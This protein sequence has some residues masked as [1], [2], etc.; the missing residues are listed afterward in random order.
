MMQYEHQLQPTH[1]DI[2]L[3]QTG[4][5]DVKPL[6]A[7]INDPANNAHIGRFETWAHDFTELVAEQ[8]V[9]ESCDDIRF[10]TKMQYRIIERETSDMIGNVSL[11]NRAGRS[12]MLGYFLAQE[13]CGKGYM[14]SAARRVVEYGIELWDLE[15]IELQIIDENVASQNVAK[16]LG[17]QATDLTIP[18]ETLEG[19]LQKRLWKTTRAQFW[20]SA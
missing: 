17:A 3:R 1:P 10:G 7:L 16:R 5:R 15:Q 18:A 20:A 19:T 4:M 2:Y 14:T 8:S 9:F 13:A 11:F 12:A 6:H